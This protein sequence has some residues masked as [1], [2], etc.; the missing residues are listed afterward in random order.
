ML[1]ETLSILSGF[2]QKSTS[3][4]LE[5][6]YML[7]LKGGLTKNTPSCVS[8]VSDSMEGCAEV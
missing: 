6:H 7:Y 3:L 4:P 2:C 1:S 8:E 5:K